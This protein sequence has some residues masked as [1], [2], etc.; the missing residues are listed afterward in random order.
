MAP[1]AEDAPAGPAEGAGDETACQGVALAKADL[2]LRGVDRAAV[3]SDLFAE[4]P[5]ILIN[6]RAVRKH[7]YWHHVFFRADGVFKLT[8]SI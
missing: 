2:E 8:F 4:T 1:D 5:T 7:G 3:P 6:N